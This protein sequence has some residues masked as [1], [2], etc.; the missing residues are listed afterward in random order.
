MKNATTSKRN[1]QELNASAVGK[2][3]ANTEIAAIAAIRNTANFKDEIN[4]N[5]A[6]PFHCSIL[7]FQF[8]YYSR[9]P[10]KT[11]HILQKKRY[12]KSE[13]F[14]LKNYFFI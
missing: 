11:L 6:V 9:K 10:I 4:F 14:Y 12:R 7:K 5:M 3:V 8:F 2:I 1:V 13:N